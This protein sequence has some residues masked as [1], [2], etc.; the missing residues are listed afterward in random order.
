MKPLLIALALTCAGCQTAYVPAA[1]GRV[2]VIDLVMFPTS[3]AQQE[4]LTHGYLQWRD[5]LARLYF[6]ANHMARHNTRLAIDV[7]VAGPDQAS[8]CAGREVLVRGVM[9]R[10]T[11]GWAIRTED[12]IVC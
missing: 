12:G 10:T 8:A 4:V 11:D 7:D 6:D 2:S 5:G 9:T 3:Y 1:D